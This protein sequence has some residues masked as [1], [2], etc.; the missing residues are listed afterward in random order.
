MP[1]GAGSV[2]LFMFFFLTLFVM[3]MKKKKNLGSMS[4]SR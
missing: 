4:H 2:K 1:N 3:I